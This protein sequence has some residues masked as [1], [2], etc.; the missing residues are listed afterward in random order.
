[1]MAAAV[2]SRCCCTLHI[3]PHC[4]GYSKDESAVTA[5]TWPEYKPGTVFLQLQC[6]LAW[7][8]I[9]QIQWCACWHLSFTLNKRVVSWLSWDPSWCSSN[10]RWRIYPLICL[11][12]RLFMYLFTY[13]YIYLLFIYTYMYP[14]ICLL[15]CL[16]VYLCTYL[17]I[18]WFIIYLS[19]Y[20]AVYLH[21]HLFI[22]SF[23]YYLFNY[24]FI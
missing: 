1:M 21:I 12:V 24:I 6:S 17:C 4:H 3:S 7:H 16:F 19:I 23:I 22:Y 5:S 8:P 10:V 2:C 15:V 9:V 18:H 14:F 13:V 11:L 20:L